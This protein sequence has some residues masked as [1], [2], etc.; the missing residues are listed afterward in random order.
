MVLSRFRDLYFNRQLLDSY[1]ELLLV[2][3][4]G[5]FEILGPDRETFRW[6]AGF[7]QRALKLMLCTVGSLAFVFASEAQQSG[8]GM[9]SQMVEVDGHKL[10]VRTSGLE[11]RKKGT[12]VIV[13]EAGATNSLEVW[14]RVLP[15]VAAFAPLVAYDRSGLGKSE[16]DGE[17]PS[18][19]HVSGKFH[20]MLQKIGVDPPY[21]IVGYSWGGALARY[22]AGYYPGDVTGLVYVDPSPIVTQ[23][24]A[25]ELAPFDS[26][27][28]GRAGYDALWQGFTALFKDASPAVKEEFKVLRGLMEENPKD[29]DL[30]PAPDVP[31]VILIAAKPYPAFL[32][33]PYDQQAQFK[34]D[35]RHRIKKLQEWA[36]DSS[37]GTLV[38]SNNTTHA[39]PRE[40]HHL[41]VWA[42]KRVISLSASQ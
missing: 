34:V 1:M 20:R 26:V 15:E 31:V 9:G 23:T 30:R 41:I 22:F 42:I 14:N 38:V 6:K 36:L 16:W 40:D 37:H 25:D 12:P 17:E 29:R 21:I 35:V 11:S 28:A 8:A 18:P 33:L 4:Q 13:F 24:M 5:H 2:Y 27:G 32:K 10:H 19:K 3:C 39:I 7:I